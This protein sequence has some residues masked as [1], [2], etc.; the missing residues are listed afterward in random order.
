MIK[1][2]LHKM[3]DEYRQSCRE[4]LA[5]GHKTVRPIDFYDKFDGPY[6]HYIIDENADNVLRSDAAIETLNALADAGL[7]HLPHE[8][9]L[10]EATCYEKDTDV[11]GRGV[12]LCTEVADK[13]FK[14][15]ALFYMGDAMFGISHVASIKIEGH[16]WV[17]NDA[18]AKSIAAFLV[19]LV[20]ALILMTHTRGMAREV[21]TAECLRKFNKARTKLGRPTVR[22][23]TVLKIGTVYDRE[24]KAHTYSL[25][26]KMRP[27]LRKGYIRNQ[28]VGVG[29][30]QTKPTWVSP[31]FVNY[32]EGDPV[33]TAPPIVVQA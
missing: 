10:I 11:S 33:P 5:L 32:V 26:C 1:T 12:L 6:P 17:V 4:T 25:G 31:T 15:D 29:R 16:E 14:V 2:K 9:C 3:L 7:A 23:Y 24:G 27:H 18:P 19:Y 13:H 8:M 22:P 30:T 21:V 28:R 20:G